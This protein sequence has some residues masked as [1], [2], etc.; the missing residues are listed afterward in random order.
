[1]AAFAVTYNLQTEFM[2]YHAI[3][4]GMPWGDVAAPFQVLILALMRA[5]GGAGLAVVVLELF[6][7]LFPFRQGAIWARWAIPAGGLVISFGALYA[8]VDVSLNTPATPPWIAPV[9]GALLLIA[10]LVLSLGQPK[11]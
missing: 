5:A 3:A 9:V 2:P 4:V 7:L 6:L 8:M 1:M 10:G 11:T